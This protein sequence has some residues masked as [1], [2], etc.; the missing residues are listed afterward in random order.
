MEQKKYKYRFTLFTPCYNSAPFIDRIKSS[1][2]NQTFRDFEWI[3]VNDNS[4]DNTLELL[5]EYIKTVDFPVKLINNKKN[6]MLA[7]NYNLAVEQTEGEY[8][9]TLDHDDEYSPRYLE[10]MD[11][12]IK[13]YD[14]PNVAGVVAR[15]QTQYGKITPMPE[16]SKPLMNWFEYA[17]DKN[18]NYTGEVP[19]AFKTEI[20]RKY[21][22]FEP[23]LVHNPLIEAM[24]SFD[25]Y[26]FITT[27]E[28]IRK[29]YVYE[30]THK[31]I[32]NARNP[33]MNFYNWTCA[34]NEISKYSLKYHASLPVKYHW[35]QAYACAS[36]RLGYS[37]HET[38]GKIDRWRMPILWLYPISVVRVFLSDVPLLHKLWTSFR[39]F[40]EKNEN[41][42]TN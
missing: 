19:R 5:E 37:L 4:S 32:S 7:V 22:P 20:L 18:G 40:R 15:C 1:V 28:I 6:M 16:Y 41:I 38:L 11:D 21:M 39:R 27:N 26:E 36:I 24:M 42:K 14:C 9:V 10:I 25:G 33:K 2:E 17:K 8:F 35:C 34:H 3:V 12:L 13:E 23:K 29:Y 30:T 31:S